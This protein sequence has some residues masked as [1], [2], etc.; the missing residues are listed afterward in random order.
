MGNKNARKNRNKMKGKVFAIWGRIPLM[1]YKS[2]WNIN[3]HA[4]CGIPIAKI[5]GRE[6]IYATEL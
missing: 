3:E 1:A 6:K 5:Q 4:Q 2:V